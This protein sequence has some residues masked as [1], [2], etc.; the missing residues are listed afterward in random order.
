MVYLIARLEVLVGRLADS[1]RNGWGRQLLS[2]H[3]HGS[4]YRRG[5]TRV[6]PQ[7]HGL[8]RYLWAPWCSYLPAKAVTSQ[9]SVPISIT[10]VLV[11]TD[12]WPVIP[13]TF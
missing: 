12:V 8:S 7:G 13:G 6:S 5:D 1:W 11:G 3:R 2:C 9:T 10:S 4:L